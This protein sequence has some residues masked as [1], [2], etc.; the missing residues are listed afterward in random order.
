MSATVP[1]LLAVLKSRLQ[2]ITLANGY[3]TDV[4]AV[5]E[6]DE[7]LSV[8]EAIQPTYVSFSVIEDRDVEYSQDRARKAELNILVLGFLEVTSGLS[9]KQRAFASDVRRALKPWAQRPLDGKGI[10]MDQFR[11]TYPPPER[12]AALAYVDIS[13]SITFVENF[14]APA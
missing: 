7:L 10:R 3:Q 4:T 11:V 14:T 12:G 6:G 5:Y 13:F 1:E 8:D 9:A 2:Q